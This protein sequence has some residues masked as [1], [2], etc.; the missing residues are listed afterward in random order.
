M[1]IC[2]YARK[3]P[4]YYSWVKSLLWKIRVP[5]SGQTFLLKKLIKLSMGLLLFDNTFL[6]DGK[7]CKN[8]FFLLYHCCYWYIFS[9]SLLTLRRFSIDGRNGKIESNRFIHNIVLMWECT[10][11]QAVYR[12]F[13]TNWI[14]VSALDQLGIPDPSKKF[15]AMMIV[16]P[17]VDFHTRAFSFFSI[18]WMVSSIT[19]KC[20]TWWIFSQTHYLKRSNLSYSHPHRVIVGSPEV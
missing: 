12:V 14:F 18:N 3:R 19:H 5:R 13:S 17:L 16:E 2:F 7:I 11:S 20:S 8:I 6:F 1:D 15:F 9:Q 10:S 4:K